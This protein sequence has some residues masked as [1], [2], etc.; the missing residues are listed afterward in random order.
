MFPML[1]LQSLNADRG[2]HHGNLPGKG[3]QGLIPIITHPE[4]NPSVIRD[5]EKLFSLLA[6]NVYVQITGDSLTGNFGHQIQ[7]CAFYLLKKGAVHFI[8]SDA[9]SEKVRGPVLSEAAK[10]AEKIVGKENAR[11]LV[12]DNPLAVILGKDIPLASFYK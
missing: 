7:E 3:F 4:R 11:M 5:P 6:R 9:H 8:A 2:R 12:N 1:H 10:V